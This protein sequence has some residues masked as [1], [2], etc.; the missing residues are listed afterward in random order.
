MTSVGSGYD[1]SVSTYSPDGKIFQIEYA[2][3]AVEN[4]G[5]VVAIRCKD[6][7]VMGVEKILPSKM[8][9]HGSNRRLHSIDLHIGIGIAGFLADA[10]QLVNRARSEAKQYKSV[11]GQPIPIK[12]LAQRIASYNHVH[13]LYGSVRPFGCSITI[14]GIDSTGP[15]LFMIE[16]SGSC[17]GYYGTS[18]GKG[19]QAVKNELEKINFT[20]I[21]AAEAVKTIAKI[22]YSVHDGDKDKDFELELSWIT[23]ESK[24][25]Q[26]VPKEIHDN[27]EAFAKQALEEANL[28]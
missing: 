4:S 3:K 19:K 13:T 18:M 14:A 28:I 5:T 22:I 17:L 20:E 8:L 10:R 7:V 16:P 9:C 15:Q 11:Y 12:V 1:L 25:H 27:A 2:S 21:T 26:L 24:I 6:G 23:R